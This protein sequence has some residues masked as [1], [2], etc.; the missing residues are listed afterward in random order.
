LFFTTYRFHILEFLGTFVFSVVTCISLTSTPK[1]ILNIY[2]NPLTLRLVLFFNIVAASVPA[3]LVMLNYEY[4]EIVSHEIEYLNEVTMS[5]VDLVLL[6]SLCSIEGQTSTVW[7]ASIASFISLVQL[8]VYNCMGRTE[9]GDMAGEVPAHF[10][11]FSFEIISS[12]IA[13]WFCMDNKYVC[14]KEIGEI[15]YGTHEY[16]NI[17]DASSREFT[18]TYLRSGSGNSNNNRSK[19]AKIYG[20]V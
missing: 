5:F 7:M 4:F 2:D 20:S 8:A 16:C 10:L 9:D 13:F 12:L 17:C 6:W 15:L 3:I 14:G 11:E 18:G 19:G 1:S